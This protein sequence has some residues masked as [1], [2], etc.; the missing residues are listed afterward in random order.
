MPSSSSV[1]P[2]RASCARGARRPGARSTRRCERLLDLALA[3]ESPQGLRALSGVAEALAAG[4][5]PGSAGCGRS[6]PTRWPP[7]EVERLLGELSDRGPGAARA[8]RRQRRRG[9]HRHR[10]AHRA[11]RGRRRPRPRSCSPAGCWCRAA[12]A[13]WCCPARSA[14]RC[15]AGTPRAEPVDDAARAGHLRARPGHGRPGRRGR[16]VRGGTPRRAAARPVGHR[17]RRRALRSGGLGVRDLKATAGRAARR[18]ADRRAAGRGRRRRRAARD[19]RPTPTAT[20]VW[21]PT[22]AF[23]AWTAR[24]IAERWTALVRAWLESPRL[25]GLVGSRDP[26]GK[27]WNALAPELAGAHQVESRRM[28]LDVLAELPAGR[29]AGHRHRRCRRWWPRVEW[30]RPRRPRTR[31][32]QVGVGGRARRRPS[33]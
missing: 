30:L 29:G 19:R 7:A 12:A 8:R 27:T 32:D 21:I 3:W 9:D 17:T 5:P 20:R 31:A 16:G 33:A 2:P 26:A 10:P 18:R 13:S 14:S 23:D 24:P 28:T 25:P 11:A 6:P 15:A 4:R 22:D 1:K